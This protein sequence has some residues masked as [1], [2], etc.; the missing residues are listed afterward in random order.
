MSR[1]S[2]DYKSLNCKID[3]QVSNE[4]ENF[5]KETGLSKTVT[6]EKALTMYIEKYKQTGKI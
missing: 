1:Q 5:I 6:V 2:K 4:L 3:K